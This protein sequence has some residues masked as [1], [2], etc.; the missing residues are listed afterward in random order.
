MVLEVFLALTASSNLVYVLRCP[1][2]AGTYKVTRLFDL[3]N[4]L[5]EQ[6]D[7]LPFIF[8]MIDRSLALSERK[9]EYQMEVGNPLFHD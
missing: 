5:P 9:N 2:S 6:Q 7:L 8:Q 1:E 3:V 4:E